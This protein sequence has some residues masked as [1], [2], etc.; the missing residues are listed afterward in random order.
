[1][2]D[3]WAV[4]GF[5]LVR[6]LGTDASGRQVLATDELTGTNVA[7]RYLPPA[8]PRDGAFAHRMETLSQLEDDNLVQVYQLVTEGDEAAIVSEYFEG[9]ALRRLLTDPL[10]PESA[11]VV[12]SDILLGL[13]A[14]H[15]KGVHHGDVTPDRVLIAPDGRAKLSDLGIAVVQGRGAPAG[16][17]AYQAPERW[18]GSPQS[19][20]ADIYAATAVFVE[21]LTGR[22]LFPATSTSGLGKA[23]NN[24]AVPVT[25]VPGPL[26][27]LVL[28]GLAKSPDDR[29]GSAAD[30]LAE[31]DD[32]VSPV[33][34]ADWEKRGRARVRELAK[35]AADAPPP[36]PQQ[37]S[38]LAPKKDANGLSQGGARRGPLLL[39]S[40]GVAAVLVVGGVAYAANQG[41]DPEVVVSP[42][43]TPAASTPLATATPLPTPTIEQLDGPGLAGKITTAVD[44]KDSFALGFKRTSG[45]E[46]TNASGWVKNGDLKINLAGP[47]PF[48]KRPAI[49]IGGTAHVQVGANWQKFPVGKARTYGVLAAHAR[50]GGSVAALTDLLDATETLSRKGNTRWLG[51][52]TDVS[53][54][55]DVAPGYKKAKVSYDLT[56]GTSWL[57]RQLKLVITAEGKPKITVIT[58]YSKWGGKIT[59]KPPKK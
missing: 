39:L 14:A 8:L 5:S 29:P 7:I 59:I 54:L 47:K 23:H 27:P 19:D 52:A 21:C 55:D 28:H 15:A 17:P 25:D 22:R 32:A 35:R 43:S 24:M 16:N 56:I 10:D 2:T 40:G 18:H 36:P 9:V 45:K 46:S 34:G 31:L 44:G 38:F 42:T 53:G 51:T 41:G 13:A 12:L 6:E 48:A 3:G 20:R 57:P 33:F 30:F 50:W 11:V 49:V 26:R 1:M 37:R 58:T 4:P